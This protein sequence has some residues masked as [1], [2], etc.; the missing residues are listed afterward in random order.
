MLLTCVTDRLA[1]PDFPT[2]HFA[3]IECGAQLQQT[4]FRF[5]PDANVCGSPRPDPAIRKD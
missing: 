5:H 4:A 1:D 2:T 3:G